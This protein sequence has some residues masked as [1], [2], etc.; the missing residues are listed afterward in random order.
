MLFKDGFLPPI[1]PYPFHGAGEVAVHASVCVHGGEG[2]CVHGVCPP[3]QLV[4]GRG[5]WAQRGGCEGQDT[6]PSTH[7]KE[8]KLRYSAVG[9]FINTLDCLHQVQV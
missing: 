4:E 9:I 3:W 8:E 6:Q 7:K 5:R 2:V 1:V